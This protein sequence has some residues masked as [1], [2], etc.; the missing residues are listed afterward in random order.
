MIMEDMGSIA[1]ASILEELHLNYRKIGLNENPFE[2]LPIFSE[3]EPVDFNDYMAPYVNSM[4]ELLHNCI[5]HQPCCLYLVGPPGSG[6]S[7]ILNALSKT[8]YQKGGLI[9]VYL[10]FPLGGGKTAF[11]N[12]LLR[13]LPVWLLTLLFEF[14]KR[15]PSELPQDYLGNRLFHA[16]F[17][18]NLQSAIEKLRISP[19]YTTK[20]IASLFFLILMVTE[21]NR[22]VLILDEFEHA[23]ARSTGLQKLNWER[24]FTELLLILKSKMIFI[25]PLLPENAIFGSR[26]YLNMYH[27]KGIDL[28]QIFKITN[29]NSVEITC[30]KEKLKGCLRSMIVKHII[31]ERGHQF[32]ASLLDKELN[33]STIG[34]AILDMHDQIV[35]KGCER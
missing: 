9:P 27:W 31:D 25:F 16:C 4:S 28:D 14:A 6:K 11:Y 30:S 19:Q 13:Q 7:A 8:L 24:A 10:R 33:Y 35:K 21:T 22:I 5:E 34:E 32:S 17:S 3:L 23:W 26:P 20:C 2:S 29:S 12:E 18:K 15:N 1:E